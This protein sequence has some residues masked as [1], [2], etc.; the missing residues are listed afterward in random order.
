[1][2]FFNNRKITKSV[3]KE[4]LVINLLIFICINR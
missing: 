4:Q 2:S 1:M 3:I